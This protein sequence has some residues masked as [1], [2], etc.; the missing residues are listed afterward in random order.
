MICEDLYKE[1]IDSKCARY[2]ELVE[3]D[4]QEYPLPEIEPTEDLRELIAYRYELENI[5]SRIKSYTVPTLDLDINSAISTRF[6]MQKLEYA[7]QLDAVESEIE[8]LVELSKREY[9]DACNR[10]RE[11]ANANISP[12][13]QK[14]NQLLNYKPTLQTV[15]ERYGITPSDITISSDITRDEFEAL[16]DEALPVCERFN[17]KTNSIVSKILKPFDG[18]NGEIIAYTVVLILASW[19]LLPILGILY[20]IN[21]IKSTRRMYGDI[22]SLRIAE[23][24]M[25]NVDFNK[26]IPED[27]LVLP[28]YDD[29]DIL[30]E[31][32]AKRAEVNELNPEEELRVE[33]NKFRT[34]AGINYLSSKTDIAYTTATNM[35]ENKIQIIA[36]KLSEL[37]DTIAELTMD[38]PILGDHMNSSTV[39][40]TSF[41]IGMIQ[42]EIPVKKDF[43]LTNINFV[44]TYGET[45][46]D[47]IKMLYVNMLMNV[48]ANSLETTIFDTEYLGQSFSEF[49]TP[50]TTNYIKIF[51]KAFAELQTDI[52]KKTSQSI[53][54]LK[55][56]DILEYNAHNEELG[57]IT[58]VYNLYIMLTGLDEKFPENKPL[59][60]LLKYSASK[61]VIVWTVYPDEIPGVL[62][63][64]LPLQVPEG[65]PLHY[66]Y[67]LGARALET[68]V[69]DS[70]NN[71]PKTLELQKGYIDKY[72]PRENWWKTKTIKEVNIRLGLQDG[73]PS[74]PYRDNFND[75]NVHFI[76]GG[77]TGS[78]KSV[79]LD[80]GLQNLIHEHA[81]DELQIVYLDM[82]NAEIA[83]YIQDGRCVI[84]HAIIAAGT[85]D[86]EYCASIFDWALE[87][88]KRRLDVCG[89]YGLQKV[90]D[91]RKMY[92]D[93]TREDYNPEV[94]IPRLV[95]II[96]EF[97]VLFDTSRIPIKVVTKISARIESLVRLSRAAGIHLWPLSQDTNNTIP[98]NVLDNFSL[99]GALR[100]TKDTSTSLIGNDA[101]GTIK[102]KVGWMYTNDSA[103][104]RKE[105]N[106]L[107]KIPYAP[108]AELTRNAFELME[109]ADSKGLPNMHA[110]FYDE[111]QGCK[112]EDLVQA[113]VEKEDFYNPN[114]FVMGSRTI[115]VTKKT[116]TNFRLTEDD[117]ENII[118]VA[119]ERQ[120]ALDLTAT[121]IDN[122]K[123]KGV[124]AN[125]LINSSDKDTSYLLNLEQYMPEDWID[126][127]SPSYD[128]LDI[129][130]DLNEIADDREHDG[131]ED[132]PV[133][134][135]MCLM[136]EKRE[137]IG[138]DER[139]NIQQAF[140]DVMRRLNGLKT[141]FI[142]VSRV[143]GLPKSFVTMCNHHICAKAESNA[144]IELTGDTL[145]LKYPSPNGDDA[146]F[147][148][149]TYGNDCNKFK[150]YRHTLERELEAREL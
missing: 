136:W 79:A 70:I 131:V 117:R 115:Y 59:M 19:I 40:D 127:M 9:E 66:D 69:Y 85:T 132:A 62:N 134:Y 47:L 63:I 84:P 109:L 106:R 38:I 48:R 133:L 113:Y 27:K 26:F 107:W 52:Q 144:C 5:Q 13:K 130:D 89:K 103:G 57:M 88:M 100:C 86:G 141:H 98:K 23:S 126:F 11:E 91:L 118:T 150:I 104:Q 116:P 50:E 64:R 90:E 77:A 61:G 97:S 101:A 87:E 147:A 108:G 53:I 35:W 102:D 4:L 33:L 142:F 80:V 65:E 15:M 12:L 74:K 37:E 51:D 94:H 39:L 125:L 145:P 31:I 14:H 60:E 129:I 105:A 112:A 149:Y 122:I 96:D 76:V 114:I 92:D 30:P 7:R 18:S 120:D 43:G 10:L 148:L 119:F 2:L 25:F 138:V 82:K 135:I 137:G 68:F 72:L 56:K 34:D 44:S 42:D 20:T 123:L 32:E 54:T 111:K 3:L 78:G 128:T 139:M 49:V 121:F 1:I 6:Q 71:K 146:C 93:P 21:M 45:T 8:C 95:I 140:V 17:C 124:K 67:D 16:L 73:D 75:Q 99:R 110:K 22:E 41:I 83:K 55:T 24:V 81:P 143:K 58:Q 29:S 46:I 36:D 28:E